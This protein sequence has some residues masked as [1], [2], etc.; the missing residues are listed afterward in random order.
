MM[1]FSKHDLSCMFLS[2][3]ETNRIKKKKKKTK[4][5]H[6]QQCLKGDI[7]VSKDQSVFWEHVGCTSLS[8]K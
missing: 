3:P 2:T 6:K 5:V 4:L 7:P 1:G 8:E